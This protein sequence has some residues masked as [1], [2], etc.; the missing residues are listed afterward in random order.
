MRKLAGYSVCVGLM[1]AAVSAQ[2][3]GPL[4]DGKEPTIYGS[5][6]RD[7]L[8]A[9]LADDIIHGMGGPDRIIGLGG[10][11]IIC[12]G[13]GNDVIFGSPGADLISGGPGN[14]L[15][16]G[17]MGNDTLWGDFGDDRIMGEIGSDDMIGGPGN[18]TISGTDFRYVRRGNNPPQPVPLNGPRDLRQG[19]EDLC[20][21]GPNLPGDIGNASGFSTAM[22]VPVDDPGY[23]GEPP[24]TRPWN[25]EVMQLY[26]EDKVTPIPVPQE[27]V[28]Q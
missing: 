23:E 3:V 28:P 6:T 18:D 19:D 24:I 8:I 20:I 2:A 26:Y 16:K 11:D 9:T 27:Q 13:K 21:E 17:G 1:M 12:G 14:D 22:C 7:I 5:P 4:C 25:P 15:I 10:N